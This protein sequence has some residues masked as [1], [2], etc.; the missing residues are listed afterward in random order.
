MKK[1]IALIF[2]IST[3]FTMFSCNK[4]TDADL[5]PDDNKA[6]V[7]NKTTDKIEETTDEAT[8]E[9]EVTGDDNA[10]GTDN[11]KSMLYLINEDYSSNLK[12]SARDGVNYLLYTY[13]LDLD[14][15]FIESR[16]EEYV[17]EE[18]FKEWNH[19]E[20][21]NGTYLYVNVLTY[22]E[23]FNFTKEQFIEACNMYP[24][25]PL[26]GDRLYEVADV[27]FSEDTEAILKYVK[28]AGAVYSN[29]KL[30]SAEWLDVHTIEDFIAEDIDFDEIESSKEATL[31]TIQTF[32]IHLE[33][34]YESKIVSYKNISGI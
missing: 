2:L 14:F 33:S 8:D 27:L 10:V 9:V 4:A 22:I 30:Y 25:F 15:L 29:N 5:V 21:A 32:S 31:K 23:H 6:I 12:E 26:F 28:S 17:G 11:Y 16:L 19:A 3:C 1:V 24:E 34:E 18:E 7:D 20:A 13:P